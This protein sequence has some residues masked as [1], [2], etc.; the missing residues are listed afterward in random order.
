MNRTAA[1]V[2]GDS[3]I[4]WVA[5]SPT[6]TIANFGGSNPA[7]FNGDGQLTAADIDLFGQALRS[8]NPAAQFDLNG[9]GQVN[10]ADRDDL[11]FNRFGTTY[12]DSNLDGR[13]NSADLVAIFVAGEF[14]DGIAGNSGWAE[15]DWNLD[16]DFGTGD[17]VAAFVA[18]GYQANAVPQVQ[19]HDIAFADLDDDVWNKP[20]KNRTSKQVDDLV[21][22]LLA[23]RI[24]V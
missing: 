3:P 13:F 5:A 14:E 19:L 23:D 1:D 4:S 10:E 18:G 6:P 2:L 24:E 22:D 7:D 21:A 9:D 15:G 8:P 12:G 20:L 16:G 11:I 17:L